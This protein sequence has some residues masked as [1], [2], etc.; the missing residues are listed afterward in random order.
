[1]GPSKDLQSHW[2]FQAHVFGQD[3]RRRPAPADLP[4]PAESLLGD[5]PI[6]L[7]QDVD[8]LVDRQE[9]ALEEDLPDPQGRSLLFGDALPED[10][11]GHVAFL[12]RDAAES[13]VLVSEIGGGSGDCFQSGIILDHGAPQ[14]SLLVHQA[15]LYG[16]LERL[17]D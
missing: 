2:S 13:G 17:F 16:Q 14:P 3:D 6:L 1:M 9:A 10:L 5:P 15:R 4:D 11:R 8:E 7:P 12:S